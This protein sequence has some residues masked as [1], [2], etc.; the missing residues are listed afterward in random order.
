MSSIKN[1]SLAGASGS[2]GRFVLEKLQASGKF[3]IKILRRQGSSS[4]FPSGVDV[5]DVDYESLEAVTAAL[6]GQDA[7]VSTVGMPQITAQN[8]LIDASIAAGVKR[9]IPSDYG[10]DLDN[11]GVR[12]L[13][14]YAQK[15][16]VQDYLIGKTKTTDLSYTTVY[17]N[18]FLDWGLEHDFIFKTSDYRPLIID[19]GDLTFSSTSL[20]SVADAVVGVLSHPEET[21]N[22]TVYIEDVK[23]TQNK[24]LELAKKAA[25]EKPWEPQNVKLDD[26]TAKSDS[27]LAQGLFDTETFVPYL[28]RACLDP[29]SGANFE[30]TDNELLGVKGLT[31]DEVLGYV[32]QYV[33]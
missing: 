17:N 2:L 1:V 18:A 14:V 27:R 6:K 13:P 7:L 31:E 20:P 25:P 21:K 10:S 22:R 30:K 5:V 8:T 15:V 3:N 28:Y 19:G 4:T 32:K 29:R 33:K 9:F 11:P 16:E 23:I 12:K 26:L 24:L